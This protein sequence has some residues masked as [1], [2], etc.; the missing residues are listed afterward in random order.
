MY[1]ESYGLIRYK[2]K[3]GVYSLKQMCK[4]VEEGLL[5]EEEFKFITDYDYKGVKET[6]GW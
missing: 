6:R 3:K 4:L 5:T 1:R 2:F